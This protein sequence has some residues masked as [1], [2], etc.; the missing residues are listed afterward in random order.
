MTPNERSEYT[1][2]RQRDEDE[3]DEVWMKEMRRQHPGKY[4]E[5]DDDEIWAS[6]CR[7]AA[8]NAN[9]SIERARAILEDAGQTADN[10][11]GITEAVETVLWVARRNWLLSER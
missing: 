3:D 11:I 6:I 1:M 8:K 2:K 7:I 4:A 5:L 9:V 10:H